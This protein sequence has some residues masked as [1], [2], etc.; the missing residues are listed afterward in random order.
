MENLRNSLNQ[1]E[2]SARKRDQEIRERNTID[3]SAVNDINSKAEKLGFS[4]YRK[5]D[6]NRALFTQVIDDNLNILI[7]NKY[8]STREFGF[9]MCIQPLIEFQTNT[10]TDRESGRFMTITDIANYLNRDRSGFSR[11]V[12]S[13]TQ[14]GVIF[15][16]VDIEEIKQYNRNLS[17]RTLF[18]NP[19]IMYKGNRNEIDGSLVKLVSHYDKMEK[20]NVLLQWKVFKKP[21]EKYGKLY[22]RKTY[23]RLRKKYGK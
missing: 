13:L 17:P 6:K 7:K 19:E 10:I 15:E 2:L 18:V 14:K 5:K 21:N 3:L 1:A 9:L 20:N 23:L 4:L 11:M 16:F 8:L 22:H 12:K